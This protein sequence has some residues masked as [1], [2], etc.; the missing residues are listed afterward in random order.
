MTKQPT[1][2]KIFLAQLDIP[3][4]QIMISAAVNCAAEI[5][6][7]LSFNDADNYRI[8][9]AV[10]E[11]IT[12]SINHFS[13]TP[14]DNERIH[15]EF[16]IEYGR[17]VVS[18]KEKGIPFNI[19]QAKKYSS[20][21]ISNM[22]NPGLGMLLMEKMV[23][24]LDVFV[25]GRDGKE[26]LLSKKLPY[27]IKAGK[28]LLQQ[29]QP[30]RKKRKIVHNF[31]T[32]PCKLTELTDVCRLAWKCY[33]YTQEKFIYDLDEITRKVKSGEFKSIV[34]IDT[35]RNIVVGHIG[36]KYHD[37]NIQVSEIAL[38]FV[39]PSYRCPGLTKTYG[40]VIRTAATESG[41]RGAFDCSVTTHTYSQ[42][43]LQE[44]FGSSP[45]GLLLAITAEGMKTKGLHTSTQP[46]GATINH[47]YAFDRS[48]ETIYIPEQHQNMVRKIYQW[49]Q[50]P[51][52]FGK[53]NNAD[54]SVKSSTK[55]MDL[56]DEIN[57]SFIIAE[58]IGQNSIA[59]IKK[60]L[61]I[62]IQKRKDAIYIFIPTN[63]SSSPSLVEKLEEEGFSFAGVMPHIHDGHDRITLQWINTPIDL[64]A[65]KI[66][67]DKGRELFDYVKMELMRVKNQT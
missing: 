62:C 43:G 47:Y 61:Q 38:T 1:T 37:P 4:N 27:G 28:N 35:D 36:L 51:R 31:I 14:D 55:I 22:S 67:G 20:D 41:D 34:T 5:G 57:V 59:E 52:T 21:S 2:S 8:Q 16:Y 53:Q 19:L 49:M 58:K 12:N 24:S 30:S 65:I 56:P 46:K 60:L 26:I 25:H 42:R 63:V 54:L 9:L 40:D 66:Y 29:V 3:I 6:N 23:D 64:D 44:Y 7:I 18:I 13:G 15:L 32:R 39:D 11:A 45:C 50:T 17:L 48:P 33:G 10:E